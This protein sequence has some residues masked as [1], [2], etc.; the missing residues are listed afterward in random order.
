MRKLEL[1]IL[2]AAVL[3][4]GLVCWFIQHSART[5]LQASDEALRRQT[6]QLASWAAENERLS[7]RLAGAK[8]VEPLSEEQFRE[9]LR[10]RNKVGQ[11]Y[12]GRFEAD[13]LR[14]ANEQLVQGLAKNGTNQ[15][16]WSGEDLAYAGFTDPESALRTT[17]FAWIS[18]DPGVFVA[19]C[20]PEEQAELERSREGLSEAEFAA[21]CKAISS[22]YSPALKGVRVLGKRFASDDEAV[23]DLYFEGDGKSRE[24]LLKKYNGEWKVTGLLFIFN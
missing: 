18:G 6:E 3:V 5:K 11:L 1:S 16:A 12:R 9:L 23:V 2:A 17:L 15:T 13:A 7:N 22:L 10:L 20:T 19:S 24:F 14:A 8:H 21:R 4:G